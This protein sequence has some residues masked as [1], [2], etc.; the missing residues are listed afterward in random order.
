MC[1]VTSLHSPLPY[2]HFSSLAATLEEHGEVLTILIITSYDVLFLLDV[3]WK[4]RVANTRAQ[5]GFSWFWGLLPAA[6]HL[7]R[8][9]TPPPTVS[10]AADP[11]P[12]LCQI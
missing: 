2:P 6:H 5:Q 4:I 3:T 7:A 12:P 1:E 10:S 9:G 11:L 8:G